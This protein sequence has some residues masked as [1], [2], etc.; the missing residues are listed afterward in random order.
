MGEVGLGSGSVNRT[1]GGLLAIRLFHDIEAFLDVQGFL[2]I[3]VVENE[4]HVFSPASLFSG[5]IYLIKRGLSNQPNELNLP[6]LA[7]TKSTE[8]HI[9]VEFAVFGPKCATKE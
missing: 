7:L 2:N 3:I 1:A 8:R 9:R 6:I 5:M 4:R